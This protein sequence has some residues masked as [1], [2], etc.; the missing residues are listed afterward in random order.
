MPSNH[1]KDAG[2]KDISDTEGQFQPPEGEGGK[3]EEAGGTSGMGEN[4][5]VEEGPSGEGDQRQAEPADSST[6]FVT[7]RPSI[8]SLQLDYTDSQKG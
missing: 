1:H 7:P 2:A 5:N 6:L 3:E 4:E 8:G